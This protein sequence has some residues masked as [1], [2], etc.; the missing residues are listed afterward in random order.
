MSACISSL[1]RGSALLATRVGGSEETTFNARI[2]THAHAKPAQIRRL[3]QINSRH[4]VQPTAKTTFPPADIPSDRT[5][6]ERFSAHIRSSF[7]S[8]D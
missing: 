8:T 1:D 4:S 3:G 7:G 5:S 2:T 6:G